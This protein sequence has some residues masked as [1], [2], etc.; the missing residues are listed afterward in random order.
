MKKDQHE[1]IIRGLLESGT[2]VDHSRSPC[3]EN[4]IPDPT[5]GSE[6][7]H[8]VYIRMDH[9][10][11]YSTWKQ[12]AKC[13]HLWDLDVRGVHNA[14]WRFFLK[15]R[16]VLVVGVPASPYAKHMPPSITPIY[17]Q[18]SGNQNT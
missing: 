14:M 11:E 6:S 8:I 15:E 7:A 2:P 12:V 9:A 5:Q 16:P 3:E 4:F 13:F 1:E 10:T 18:P 17:L